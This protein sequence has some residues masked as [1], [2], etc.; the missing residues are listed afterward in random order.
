[1]PLLDGLDD[2]PSDLRLDVETVRKIRI[3]ERLAPGDDSVREYVHRLVLERS[4]IAIHDVGE[5]RGDDARRE[6]DQRHDDDVDRVTQ[7]II[8]SVCRQDFEGSPTQP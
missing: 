6:C 1:L 8:G 3:V 4:F 2:F 7:L 5:A